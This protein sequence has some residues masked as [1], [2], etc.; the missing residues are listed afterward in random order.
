[1]TENTPMPFSVEHATLRFRNFSGVGGQYNQEGNRTF[2]LQLDQETA[3]K[4]EEQGW[5]VSY[6]PPL[7]DDEPPVPILR[8][9]VKWNDKFPQYDPKIFEITDFGKRELDETTVVKLDAATIL[10]ADVVIRPYSWHIGE[11]GKPNYKHGVKAMLKTMYVT[12][13]VDDFEKKYAGLPDVPD[14]AANTMT[15]ERVQK[16]QD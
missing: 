12:L 16:N 2:A 15:F 14:S 9:A 10:N 3:I 6:L 5:N 13:D 1:M 8:V 11:P 7:D 4:L